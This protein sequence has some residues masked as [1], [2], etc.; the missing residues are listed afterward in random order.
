[1]FLGGSATE[2]HLS[3][4]RPRGQHHDAAAAKKARPGPELQNQI[5]VCIDAINSGPTRVL[6]TKIERNGNQCNPSSRI[7]GGSV[8]ATKE[9]TRE[10]D[11]KRFAE[12]NREEYIDFTY[13]NRSYVLAITFIRY[14][15]LSNDDYIQFIVFRKSSI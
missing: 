3:R 6:I 4:V 7:G 5:S 2:I 9:K 8:G 10:E 1:M 12:R 13:N 14:Q 15:T 11:K